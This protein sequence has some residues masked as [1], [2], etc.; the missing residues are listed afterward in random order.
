MKKFNMFNKIDKSKPILVTGCAGFIASNL[1]DE[2]LKN[3]FM[4]VGLDNLGTGK[5]KFLEDATKNKNFTFYKVDL[6]STSNIETFFQNCDFVFHFA[7]NADVRFGVDKPNIDFEQNTYVTYKVLEAMRV[8]RVKKICFSSTGSIYGEAKMIPTPENAPFP[9]QT[10][11]YGASKLASEGM[12]SAYCESFNLQA[13]IF[14]FVSILGPRYSHGHVY[15][16][17]KQLLTNPLELKVLGDGSQKKSYLHITDCISGI[18]FGIN[19]LNEKVNITNLGHKSYIS[20]KE[21]INYISR[22]LSVYPEIKYGIEDRGWVGDNPF[23]FLDT[24]KINSIGWEP[25]LSIER[26]VIDTVRFLNENSWLFREND[27]D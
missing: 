18:E 24:K 6:L 10:S 19:N 13:W 27:N 23:I 11:L 8:N 4:V 26:G 21:S 5:L 15:D 1:V 2:L 22:E 16:F 3:G 14:R 20:V 25:K 9:V 17:Y 12:I 7:A